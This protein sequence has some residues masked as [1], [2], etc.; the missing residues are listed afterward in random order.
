MCFLFTLYIFICIFDILFIHSIAL[1]F[2]IL[3]YL[4]YTFQLIFKEN[5]NLPIL[6]YVLGFFITD[7]M[8]TYFYYSV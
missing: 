1:L 6:F 5:K 3:V 4:M 7:Y 8:H 2:N